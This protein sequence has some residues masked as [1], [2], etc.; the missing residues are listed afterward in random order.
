[1]FLQMLLVWRGPRCWGFNGRTGPLQNTGLLS[2]G[3]THSSCLSTPLASTT[4][5]R[6][7]YCA[8]ILC[9]RLITHYFAGRGKSSHP[10]SFPHGLRTTR[11]SLFLLC[12]CRPYLMEEPSVS[13]EQ[14]LRTSFLPEGHPISPRTLCIMKKSELAKPSIKPLPLANPWMGNACAIGALLSPP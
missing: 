10:P 11:V 13:F 12:R 7:F 8:S 2:K 6:L 9:F 4:P 5:S 3:P 1:L 14:M